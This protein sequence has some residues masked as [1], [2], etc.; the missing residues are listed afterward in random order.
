MT[1][2]NDRG[3]PA[4]NQA[5]SDVISDGD[6]SMVAA[7]ADVPRCTR[8]GHPIWSTESIR[9]GIGRDCRRQGVAA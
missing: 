8:C 1:L 7:S 2:D 6:T 3:R 9:L 5:A 4:A